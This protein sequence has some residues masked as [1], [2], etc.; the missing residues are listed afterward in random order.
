MV[1]C[2]AYEIL[3]AYCCDEKPADSNGRHQSY[4]YSQP[5]TDAIIDVCY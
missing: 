1:V 3:R 2:N 4:R 5:E